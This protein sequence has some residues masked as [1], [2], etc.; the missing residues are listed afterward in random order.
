MMYLV[1]L[2]NIIYGSLRKSY[3]ACYPLLNR[4]KYIDR[5]KFVNPLQ[6]GSNIISQE[7]LNNENYSKVM[8]TNFS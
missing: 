1:R 3:N 6:A 7:L 5:L 4:G 8:K 2:V